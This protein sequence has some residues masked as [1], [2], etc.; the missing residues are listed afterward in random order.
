MRTKY[1]TLAITF[2]VIIALSACKK[3]QS[4]PQ[5]SKNESS[6]KILAFKNMEEYQQTL[7]EVSSLTSDERVAWE[8]AKGFKSFGRVCDEVY[9]NAQPEIF[10]TLEEFNELV[11]KSSKYLYLEKL[12]N[13]ELSLEK[14][15]QKSECRYL[16]NS[17]NMFQVGQNVYK[18]LDKGVAS[19]KME[20]SNKLESINNDNFYSYLNHNE[21]ELTDG[22]FGSK[23]D[24][25]LKDVQNNCGVTASD[26]ESSG[27]DRTSMTIKCGVEWTSL[28]V[29]PYSQYSVSAYKRGAFFLP[30]VL[31][32]RHISMDMKTRVDFLVNY[33]WG[34]EWKFANISLHTDDV[35]VDVHT[36]KVY[37]DQ[38][39]GWHTD[40]FHYGGY[41]CWGDTP[42]SPTVNLECNISIL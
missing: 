32:K 6:M 14:V 3:D 27:N 34:S 28:W 42:S 24:K 33:S 41:D 38:V 11:S 36:D 19:V 17:D 23:L 29:K 5:D 37:G 1:L 40:E 12:P 9:A 2:V 25:A 8:E 4:N 26:Y 21:I 39:N 13:G 10:T 31:V 20:N 7:K 22:I 18:I 16:I 30:W 35:F 15:L